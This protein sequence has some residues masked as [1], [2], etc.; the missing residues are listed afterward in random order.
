MIPILLILAIGIVFF[1]GADPIIAVIEYF[2]TDNLPKSAHKRKRGHIVSPRA[3]IL[4]SD[5]EV[6][7]QIREMVRK[8]RNHG[9]VTI[10]TDLVIKKWQNELIE[11]YERGDC[12]VGGKPTLKGWLKKHNIKLILSEYI[13]DVMENRK[14]EQ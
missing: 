12:Y 1:L 3:M 13:T 14:H 7:S 2:T 5:R 6:S 9:S 4:L 10:D 11:S 8:N